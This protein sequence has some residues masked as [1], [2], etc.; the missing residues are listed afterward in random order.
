M[1][2]L[3]SGAIQMKYI[4]DDY[5]K[6]TSKFPNSF[7][8]WGYMSFK[9]TGETAFITKVIKAYVY[10]EILDNFLIPLTEN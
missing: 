6:K 8:I 2:E 3:L 7:I 1:L 4:K 10:I 9:G 5:L